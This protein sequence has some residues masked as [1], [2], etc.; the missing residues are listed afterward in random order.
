[1]KKLNI[2][3]TTLLILI[4]IS[5]QAQGNF[6][7]NPK[8]EKDLETVNEYM[9]AIQ[10]RDPNQI[11]N[12][13][14]SDVVGYGPRWNSPRDRQQIVDSFNYIWG[15]LSE[16]RYE[17][18]RLLPVTISGDEIKEYNGNWVMVWAVF[19]GKEKTTGKEFMLDIHEALKIHKGK[20]ISKLS[21]Y[22]ELDTMIQTGQYTGD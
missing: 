21:F 19:V 18:V 7:V 1:M 16:F 2:I 3:L 10:S 11:E 15:S 13:H 22:N 12:I 4:S 17:R 6:K 9:M 14:A 8:G 5:I 20:V